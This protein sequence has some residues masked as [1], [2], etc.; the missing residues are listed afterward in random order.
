MQRSGMLH[1]ADRSGAFRDNSCL[2][3]LRH[4]TVLK[5][6]IILC[7]VLVSSWKEALWGSDQP[8]E[9]QP[10]KHQPNH[11]VFSSD[12]WTN[13]W[14]P[15]T[16]LRFWVRWRWNSQSFELAAICGKNQYLLT[17]S[18]SCQKQSSC[19]VREKTKVLAMTPFYK[20]AFSFVQID[21]STPVLYINNCSTKCGK[22]QFKIIFVAPTLKSFVVFIAAP[23]MLEFLVFHYILMAMAPE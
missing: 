14:L 9:H 20:S 16:M 17:L 22:L 23:K 12:Y 15:F 7:A 18:F 11:F 1:M 13:R 21:K 8:T 5:M 10:T 4:V 6:I 3:V 2:D 19:H